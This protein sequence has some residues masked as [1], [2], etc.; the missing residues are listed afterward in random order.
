MSYLK[1]LDGRARFSGGSAFKTWVF[2]VVRLTALDQRRW[3]VR[4][5]L[6]FLPLPEPDATPASSVDPDESLIR[7]E[8]EQTVRAALARLAARQAEA[9]HLV[10]Y[11]DMTL[12]EAAV[13]M[14]VSPGTARTHYERGKAALRPILSRAEKRS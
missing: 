12:D 5:L 8:R 6:R 7:G 2:G 14:R 3:S 1:I 9:L 4:H 10:F 13:V 11:H